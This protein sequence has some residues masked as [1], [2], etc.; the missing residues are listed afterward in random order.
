MEVRKLGELQW[1]TR[2]GRSQ[3]LDRAGLGDEQK[4][5]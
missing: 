2:D 3:E 1:N 4:K 5:T